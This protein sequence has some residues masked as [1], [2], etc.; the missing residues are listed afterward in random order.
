MIFASVFERSAANS[1]INSNSAAFDQKIHI[2]GFVTV[3]AKTSKTT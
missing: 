2:F 1:T 3:H